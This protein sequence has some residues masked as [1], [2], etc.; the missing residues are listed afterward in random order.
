M[1]EKTTAEVKREIERLRR[2]ITEHNFRYHILAQPI[3]ADAEYD[4]L[5]RCLQ[6]LETAHPE[7]FSAQSPTQT[8]GFPLQTDFQPVPHPLPMLSLANAF[9]LADLAEWDNRVRKLL[10][11]SG[12]ADPI[13][14]PAGHLAYAA[15]VKVDG[16]AVALHYEDGALICGLTRGD[17]LVGED[18]TFNLRT[19]K[20][21]PWQLP[22]YVDQLEVR[23]EVYMT[24]SD[25]AA[26]NEQQLRRGEKLFANPRNAAAGSVRQIDPKVTRERPLRF[27]AYAVFGLADA[28]THA[29]A[30]ERLEQLGFPTTRPQRAMGVKAIQENYERVLAEREQLPFEID[31][32]VV[33]VNNLLDQERLGA[34]GREPRWAV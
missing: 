9:S 32:L 26:L 29:H 1:S 23:G 22:P 21:I 10:V 19:I 20:D 13:F 28:T 15:E 30:L 14:D 6:E 3:I 5:F 33:K 2:E 25:F 27:L 34:V 24:K 11:K 12:S 16:L 31:G 18:I 17:G 8:V 7:C 4:R